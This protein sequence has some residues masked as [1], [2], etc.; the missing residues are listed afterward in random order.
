M[1]AKKKYTL[2]Q[3]AQLATAFGCSIQTI[4]RWIKKNDDRLTSDRA[5]SAINGK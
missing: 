4:N 3:I 2:I 5:K 1:A